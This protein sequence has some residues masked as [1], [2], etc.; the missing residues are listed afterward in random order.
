[1]IKSLSLLIHIPVP[2]IQMEVKTNLTNRRAN[3]GGREYNPREKRSRKEGRA[4][5][6]WNHP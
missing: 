2:Q 4:F 5:I 6:F 1:M 3:R